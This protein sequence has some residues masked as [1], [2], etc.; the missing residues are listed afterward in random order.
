MLNNRKHTYWLIMISLLCCLCGIRGNTVN[1]AGS[2]DE[3]NRQLQLLVAKL[4]V[5]HD[6]TYYYNLIKEIIEKS[7]ECDSLDCLPNTNGKVKPR[8]RHANSSVAG[9][10][11]RKLVD[12]GIYFQGKDTLKG[13]GLLQLYI[14]TRHHPLFDKSK[15]DI[16][17]A[18][19]CAGKMAYGIKDYS[20]AERM[21][22]LALQ[23]I[24]TAKDAA[25][26]KI[27][28]M[29][30][31]MK[32]EKDAHIY[33]NS[34][35]ALHDKDRSNKNYRE[36]IIQYFSDKGLADELAAFVDHELQTSPRNKIL[37]ALKG[38][39]SM[40]LH[41]WESAIESFKCAINLD[42]LFVPAIYNVG[43]C[44]TS[45]AVQL[46]D[47][48][49]ENQDKVQIDSINALLKEGKFYLERTQELDPNRHTVD[50]APPLYQIYYALN[51]E[52]ADYIKKLIKY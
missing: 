11:R 21:A 40:Q 6:S 7:I 28:C 36:L 5:C 3:A 4:P 26:L 20:K 35:L 24:E 17:L 22:D 23:H 15:Q 44:Y 39:R 33:I 41:Q 13:L 18:A 9:K 25:Q 46:S 42:S 32:T 50:W 19:L 47:K 29:K 48:Y 2:A 30:M 27:Y 49:K 1:H 12:G 16:G 51:D 10:L 43:I 37:W 52:R 31:L 14:D 38:E 8:Y 45:K 34:L